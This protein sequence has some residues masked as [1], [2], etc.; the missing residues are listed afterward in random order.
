MTSKADKHNESTSNAFVGVTHDM[1][2]AT[3]IKDSIRDFK[4]WAWIEHAPDN[5]DGT[6]HIHFM[7]KT[8]G[9]RKIKHIADK[10]HIPPN[11]IQVLH[12]EVGMARYFLHLDSDDKIKYSLDD[13]HTNNHGF[14]RRASK[15][16]VYSSPLDIWSDFVLLRTHAIS[17][18][19]FIDKYQDEIDKLGFYQ[20]IKVYDSIMKY[21]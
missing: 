21:T 19:E 1:T 10:L 13:V 6:P 18:S 14:F 15:E 11:F 8:N 2:C 16:S 12:N 17:S 4:F 9:T 5:D 7:C 3:F 20:K